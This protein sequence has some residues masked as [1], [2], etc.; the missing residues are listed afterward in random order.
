MRR[1]AL[2]PEDL[3]IACARLCDEMKAEDILILDVR[4]LTQITDYFLLCS[5]ASERQLKAIAD[6][7]HRDLKAQGVTCLGIEGE[8][9]GGWVLVDYVDVVVHLFSRE[10]RDFYALEMLW[11]D[12]PKADWQP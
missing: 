5:A 10:A 2:S 6:R 8:A 1:S 9:V 7:I 3:A 12:A 11:G 4:K